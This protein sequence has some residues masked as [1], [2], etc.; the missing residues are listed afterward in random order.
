MKKTLLLIASG[1]L[2]SLSAVFAQGNYYVK[3]DGNGDGSS[4]ENA[5]N[6]LQQ[7]IDNAAPGS[8]VRVAAGEYFGA[9]TMKDD[10]TVLGGYPADATTDATTDAD[11]CMP[12]SR[13]NLTSLRPLVGVHDRVLKQPE[14][15]V[16]PTL[17]EGFVIEAGNSESGNGG[18]V[19]L[20]KNGVLRNC[21]VA[22][23]ESNSNGGGIY[24]GT[25]S[26]V[27]GCLVTG[28]ISSVNGAGIYADGG[29]VVNCTVVDNTGSMSLV[30]TNSATVINTV[31]YNPDPGSE[32]FIY[33]PAS[34]SYSAAHSEP[35][36]TKNLSMEIGDLIPITDD[37]YTDYRPS[38]HSRLLNKGNPAVLSAD[39]TLDLAGNAR[40]ANGKIDIGA[41][42]VTEWVSVP[43]QPYHHVT[44]EVATGIW[45]NYSAGDLTMKE[46]DHLYFQF[47]GEELPVA[48]DHILF[49]VDGVETSFRA[50]GNIFS[51]ILSPI[52]ADH[53]VEIALREYPVTYPQIEGLAIT[54][55]DQ[56]AYGEP[57]TFT[58][59]SQSLDLTEMKVFVNGQ[60]IPANALRSDTYT[61]TTEAVSGPVVITVEGVNPTGNERIS[62][63][64]VRV[65]IENGE[66]RIEN[67]TNIS[68]EAF[69]YDLNG[70]VI[71]RRRI[72]GMAR[73]NLLP[74]VYILDA[75]GQVSKIVIPRY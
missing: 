30:V 9:F 63:A 27:E 40:T 51:Y 73:I 43:E 70:K 45:C 8:T 12:G 71:A 11:R 4:W 14:A 75:G 19:L 21:I 69:V 56:A 59:G 33:L 31:L 5:S 67:E 42:Q 49:R 55:P 58:V 13:E 18:G 52:K 48:A 57:F 28:N 32:I 44:L 1:V 22:G 10:V 7:V 61:Y 54:G 29:T 60:E 16:N 35:D 66:L 53:R 74:G 17:W 36:G 47:S 2:L 65:E 39:Y 62:P 68:F 6:D 41:Y 72:T 46:G 26:R 20:L 37:L 50:S 38:A 34:V 15:F 25:G 64:G 3:S 24:A 23:N